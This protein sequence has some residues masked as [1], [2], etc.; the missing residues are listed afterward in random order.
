MNVPMLR[1]SSRLKPSRSATTNAHAIIMGARL[2]TVYFVLM[3][4]KHARVVHA[5]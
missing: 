3:T 1:A 2:T 5:R 4:Y